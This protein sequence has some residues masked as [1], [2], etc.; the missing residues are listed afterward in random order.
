MRHLALCL[1]C[2]FL[3]SVATSQMAEPQVSVVSGKRWAVVVGASKYEHFGELG[4][5]V[6]DA[7]AFSQVLVS[8]YGFSSDTV[9]LLTDDS[10]PTMTPTAG[11]I[12]G[13]L[14]ALVADKRLEKS[15]LFVFYFSGHGIGKENADYL[16]PID[17]RPET[18][19][20]L[21]VPIKEVIKLFVDAG[22]RNVLIIADACRSGANNPFGTEL[23]AL[24]EKANIAVMLGCQPGK[25]SIEEPRLRQGIFTFK[26]I[27][28]MNDPANKDPRSGAVWASKIASTVSQSV[29]EYTEPEHGKY[30]QRP[31][32]WSDPTRD[33]LLGAFVPEVFSKE[34][35]QSFKDKAGG[36]NREAYASAMAGYAQS[37]LEQDK[38][39]DVIEVLRSLDSFA[40]L[41]PQALYQLATSL[42]LTE[43]MG[44]AN[45]E[46]QRLAKT[47]DSFYRD[48]AFASNPSL[49]NDRKARIQAAINLWKLDQSWV[50][51]SICNAVYLTVGSPDER[52]AF[53][54]EWAK[55]DAPSRRGRRYIQGE[56]YS[57]D[58]KW[59]EAAAAYEAG[60]KEPGDN[61][62][63]SLL[64]NLA[65]IAYGNAGEVDQMDRIA[66]EGTKV[67]SE[68][69][70]WHLFR[71]IRLRAMGNREAGYLEFERALDFECSVSILQLIVKHAGMDSMKLAPKIK[72][73]LDKVPYSW[74]ARIC[75][76]LSVKLG[77]PE[78]ELIAGLG[79]ARKLAD[80]EFDFQ[81]TVYELLDSLILDGV[82]MGAIPPEQLTTFRTASAP[83]LSAFAH[84]FN[85]DSNYWEPFTTLMISIQRQPILADLILK[86][87]PLTDPSREIAPDTL[88]VAYIALAYQGMPDLLLKNFKQPY[89]LDRERNDLALMAAMSFLQR[90]DLKAAKSA[91]PKD[92]LDGS[93]FAELKTC[94]EA[95]LLFESGDKAGA[96]K[97]IESIRKT[98]DEQSKI[99]VA[100]LLVLCEGESKLSDAVETAVNFSTGTYPPTIGFVY[101]KLME[102]ARK[103]ADLDVAKKLVQRANDAMTGNLSFAKIYFGDKAEKASFVGTFSYP[104]IG[105]NEQNGVVDGNLTLI[106]SADG[107]LSG[108]AQLEGGKAL[109]VSG[110][111][112]EYGNVVAAVKGEGVELKLVTK[113]PGKDASWMNP[114]GH[115]MQLWTADGK[116]T[117]WVWNAKR[118]APMN[119]CS[120]GR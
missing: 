63:T 102:F 103:K 37:L 62:E 66:E 29:F 75:Y 1:F 3:T 111:F 114:L 90:G 15:D 94:I 95:Y 91:L 31:A 13:E 57:L 51:G 92:N 79:D 89:I 9:K 112:D 2:L 115:A 40:P 24:A 30:A 72:P 105:V 41:S 78:E 61:P 12:L 65:Y 68:A 21:G 77:S 59:K 101:E 45:R 56:L 104:F 98:E 67:P 108:F 82:A 5:A 54:L 33:V 18:V 27:E 106:C 6:E 35:L 48:I 32:A 109:I 76:V 60:L 42:M 7:K 43:R 70:A 46:F 25:R 55:S 118:T 8:K 47:E 36:L 119:S 116:R 74:I 69:A 117:I 86:Y 23:Q 96:L 4:F 120:S 73:H 71:G 97:L 80:D 11:H 26:L 81:F 88:T 52:R 44:E 16:L 87:I 39:L 34:A 20:R 17:G 38:Y 22:L 49:G 64:R 10:A 100:L 110:T 107:A 84:R 83:E 99:F 14:S 93:T 28:A 85:N 58:Q 50:I 19:E 53:L 113:L